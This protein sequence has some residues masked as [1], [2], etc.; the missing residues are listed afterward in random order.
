MCY[1]IYVMYFFIYVM[2]FFIYAMCYFIY[3]MY[4]FIYVMCNYN[5]YLNDAKKKIYFG[6]L[7]TRKSFLAERVHSTG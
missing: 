1:F 4:N 7:N 2:Y 3:V 6:L 5:N